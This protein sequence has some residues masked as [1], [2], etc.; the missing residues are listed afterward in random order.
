MVCF[1]L[2]YERAVL[3]PKPDISHS[4]LS[5]PSKD[6]GQTRVFLSAPKGPKDLII[7]YLGYG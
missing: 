6:P 4:V 5:P 7:M 2:V 1:K 3:I